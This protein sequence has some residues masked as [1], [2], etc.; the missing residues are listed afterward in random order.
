MRKSD[1]VE[2]LNEK[3][4]KWTYIYHL[5][6]RYYMGFKT[7]WSSNKLYSGD[8]NFTYIS[9]NQNLKKKY[10]MPPLPQDKC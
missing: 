9:V 2:I 6:I 10:G 1:L 5:L 7:T 8:N 3:A 4:M